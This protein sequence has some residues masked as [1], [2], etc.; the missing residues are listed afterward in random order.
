MQYECQKSLSWQTK[1]MERT[2]L[3][4]LLDPDS[5]RLLAQLREKDETTEAADLV[6]QLRKAGHS[7]ERVSAVLGQWA[8]RAKAVDKFGA[9]ADRMLFTK[10]GLEQATRLAIASHHATRFEHA[11]LHSVADLGC[12]IGGDSLAF[13][14]LSLN[15]HAVDSDPVTIA[16]AGYNLQPF[17]T[18]RV[19][20]QRAEDTDLAGVEAL[21][22]DP[23]RRSGSQRLNDPADWSP[24]LEWVIEQA[25]HRP[26]GIK[27]APGMDRGLIPEGMEAQWISHHGSV[28]EMVLWSRDLA[29]PG[30]TRSALVISPRGTAEL[31]GASDAADAAV[32]ELGDYLVEPDGG[33]IRARLIGDLAREHDGVMLDDSIAY[34]ST[35]QPVTSALAQ[36][37]AIESVVPYNLKRV[38]DLVATAQVGSLEIK[39]RGIDVDPAELRKELPLDGEG[40]K[41]LILTRYRGDRIAILA[42]RLS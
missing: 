9:F 20:A 38:K 21:W 1:H 39:K 35:H 36:C 26:A 7:A 28:A 34:F 25:R 27:L 19:S 31:T 18:V 33:V 13:A 41:T 4:A 3:E 16:I 5:L 8:L 29:R 12:G 10:Q 40:E 14:G 30:I 6:P 24:G 32:G 17:D 42:S 22:L 11:N 15:V 2:E 37:F 23:A